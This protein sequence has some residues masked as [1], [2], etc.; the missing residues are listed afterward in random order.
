MK[1][2]K[3]AVFG[4]LAGFLACCLSGTAPVR[5]CAADLPEAEAAVDVTAA[6]AEGGFTASVSLERMPETGLCA[7]E[8]ALRYDAAALTVTDV[9]LLYDTGAQ[10]AEKL[11]GITGNDVFTYENTDG[12]LKIRWGTA[13]KADYW[14]KEERVFFTVSGTVSEDVPAGTR[15]P[16]ELVPAAGDTAGAVIAAGWLDDNDVLQPCQVTAKSGA[17]WKP[18]NEAGV[19]MYGDIDLDGEL[20]VAD[21]VLLHR[22]L[23]EELALSAAAYANADC[24][25]DG[26]LTMCDVTLMLRR[27]QNP[28]GDTAS[29]TH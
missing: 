10:K 15:I 2:Q 19:T 3:A 27:I 5:I 7:M 20:T 11:A 23:N 17:V 13:A 21:A 4:L 25:S 1:A 12:F 6:D 9:T 26:V 29:E 28:A 24:E 16:I 18:I 8:F 14:L 22:A